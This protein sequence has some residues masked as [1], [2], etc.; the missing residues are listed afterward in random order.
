MSKFAYCVLSNGIT[1]R[2][3]D[4]VVRAMRQQSKLNRDLLAVSMLLGFTAFLLHKENK[5]LKKQLR[6]KEEKTDG[7]EDEQK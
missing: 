2:S 6:E 5:K 7:C 4:T 1:D 3:I